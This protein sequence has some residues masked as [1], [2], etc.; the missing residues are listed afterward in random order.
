[1]PNRYQVIL[2]AFQ[3]LRANA[4]QRKRSRLL[5]KKVSNYRISRAI[6]L[7][8]T[9]A[10][11]SKDQP[12]KLLRF[13]SWVAQAKQS[14]MLRQ[15]RADTFR[16]AKLSKRVVRKWRHK[17]QSRRRRAARQQKVEAFRSIH[18]IKRAF[19]GLQEMQSQ[20]NLLEREADLIYKRKV[21][22][23]LREFKHAQE[24]K[25]ASVHSS[26]L[27]RRMFCTWLDAYAEIHSNAQS[28]ARNQQ[29]NS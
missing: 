11:R 14:I 7:L 22:K 21:L 29:N 25:A 19:S 13:K 23:S 15:A 2:S 24:K 8:Q 10:E 1:M 26:N 12:I 17:L 20:V 6:K 27:V 28:S 5:Q 16:T 4:A 18:L 3:N 9:A